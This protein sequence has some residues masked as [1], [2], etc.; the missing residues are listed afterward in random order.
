MIDGDQVPAMLFGESPDKV[1]AVLPAQKDGMAA[2]LGAVGWVTVTF[3]VCVVAHWPVFG[4]KTYEPLIVLFIVAGDQV[5]AMLF[6]ESPVN[7]GAVLPE[8]KAGMAAKLGAVGW[9]TVT[10]RVCVVAEHG[11]FGVNT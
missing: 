3:R 4:V 1:G 11:A 9:V 6:G 5:P 7:T 2:K 10:F 8:Q